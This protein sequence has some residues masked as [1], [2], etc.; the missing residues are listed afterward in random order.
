M[1]HILIDFIISTKSTQNTHL[2]LYPVYTPVDPASFDTQPPA[3]PRSGPPLGKTEFY[4][5]SPSAG[6]H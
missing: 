1:A 6:G 4:Y 3:S 2:H 5:Q